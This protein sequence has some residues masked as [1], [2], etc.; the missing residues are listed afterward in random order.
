MTDAVLRKLLANP[1]WPCQELALRRTKITAA[2]LPAL[3][4]LGIAL[5]QGLIK[6]ADLEGLVAASYSYL[7][8]NGPEFTGAALA[9]GRVQAKYI[10]LS[11]SA[12]T[13]ENLSQFYSQGLL[14]LLD[15][16]HTNVTMAGV[17]RVNAIHLDLSH[18]KINGSEL[19]TN[20]PNI[21]S[22]FIRMRHEAFTPEERLKLRLKNV[23]WMRTTSGMSGSNLTDRR[24]RDIK[25]SVPQF[26]VGR[27][28]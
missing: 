1:N 3:N 11:G 2:V 27:S 9:S 4:G 17:Q 23:N 28:S 5:G 21:P 25:F 18:T 20:L 6:E 22:N 10:D 7:K 14:N 24:F 15:L 13:D 19:I 8:L 26:F 12:V 16:S